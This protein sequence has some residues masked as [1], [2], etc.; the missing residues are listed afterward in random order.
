MCMLDYVV[1]LDVEC[2]DDDPND[3]AFVCVTT[4]NGG[5]DAVEE[6]VARKMYPL[7]SSFGFKDVTVGTT[8]VL[9]VQTPLSVFIMG[10][11][12]VKNASHLLAEVETE[13][14]RILGIFRLKEYDALSIANLLNGGR[15]NHVFEQM[16]LAYAPRMLPGT[17]AFQVA[18]EK[19]KAEVSKNWLLKRR[20]QW[21]AEQLR[22]RRHP[23]GRYAL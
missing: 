18:K 5:R 20:K 17:E 7:A 8:L 9:K 21:Q 23:R 12:F 3:V 2:P 14:K 22:P 19:H 13:A 6:F 15:L 1:E 16:G 11:V 10:A 4:T